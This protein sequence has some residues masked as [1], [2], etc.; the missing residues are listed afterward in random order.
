MEEFRFLISYH[1]QNYCRL[2]LGS[3]CCLTCF[4]ESFF[5]NL[6]N[7]TDEK[8][9]LGISVRVPSSFKWGKYRL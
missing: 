9:E 2:I 6:H 4:K 5:E 7:A 8:C 1:C 3:N